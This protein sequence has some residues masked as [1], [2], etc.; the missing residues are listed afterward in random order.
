MV[1]AFEITPIEL[2]TVC[3]LSPTDDLRDRQ[4]SQDD[5][6]YDGDSDLEDLELEDFG[7]RPSEITKEDVSIAPSNMHKPESDALQGEHAS[8]FEAANASASDTDSDAAFVDEV[9]AI[10][11]DTSLTKAVEPETTSVSS[12]LNTTES[13]YK[14][15]LFVP[16]GAYRT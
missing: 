1:S 2:V 3:T 7:I 12:G 15:T 10:L 8:S 11:Q 6:D 5:Y 14:H 13:S 16:D 4:W 9:I